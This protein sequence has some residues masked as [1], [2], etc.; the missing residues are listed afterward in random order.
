MY[1]D[2]KTGW[3]CIAKIGRS[4][5]SSYVICYTLALVPDVGI[6]TTLRT[7]S[8]PLFSSQKSR[9]FCE[10]WHIQHVTSSPH[11][12]P[13]QR[14]EAAVKDMK[15]LVSKTVSNYKLHVDA[16]Q[17]GLLEWHNTPAPS[18]R[19][20]AQQLFGR[21]FLSFLPA[22]HHS[23]APEW[24]IAADTADANLDRLRSQ[25]RTAHDQHVRPLRKLSLVRYV[26]VQDPRTKLWLNTEAIVAIGKNRDYFVKMPSDR[27]HWRNRCFLRP[28]VPAVPPS[29]P[30]RPAPSPSASTNQPCPS[31]R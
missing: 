1:T 10:Q 23:S 2:R 7:D 6:P 26:Y 20:R 29:P 16:L 21:P 9:D 13:Q 11:Y 25:K 27:V 18:G 17:R 22:H 30:I 14:T 24:Q 12:S 19:S 5:S 3:P 4:S 28:L 15:S 31:S 8:G